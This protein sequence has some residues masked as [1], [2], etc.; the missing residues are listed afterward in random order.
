M[1]Q[2]GQLDNRWNVSHSGAIVVCVLPGLKTLK[3]SKSPIVVHC[4][5]LV[6]VSSSCLSLLGGVLMETEE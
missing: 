5:P 2:E 1:L 4:L 3:Q 6:V